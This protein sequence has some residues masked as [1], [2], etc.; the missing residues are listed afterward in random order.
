MDGLCQSGARVVTVLYSDADLDRVT[1]AIGRDSSSSAVLVVAGRR[2]GCPR[3]GEFRIGVKRAGCSPVGCAGVFNHG[4]RVGVGGIFVRACTF[5]ANGYRGFGSAANLNV[6]GI[7]L[8][9]CQA[10]DFGKGDGHVIFLRAVFRRGSP[11][12]RGS[13]VANGDRTI[14][15][16]RRGG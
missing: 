8:C 4:K 2:A 9:P 12:M 3:R 5:C 13:Q 14:G 11:G 1:R 16:L 6:Y 7:A 15:P 10:V